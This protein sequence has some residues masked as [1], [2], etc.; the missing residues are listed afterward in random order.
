MIRKPEINAIAPMLIKRY[1]G[2]RLYNTASLS[3]AT[4]GSCGPWPAGAS[5]DRA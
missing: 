1:A 2:C 4:P 3:Y 5:A